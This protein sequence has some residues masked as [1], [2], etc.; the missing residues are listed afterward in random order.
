[1][2]KICIVG[3]GIA[4]L[5]AAY[6]LR[7]SFDCT[8]FEKESYAGGHTNTIDIE[9]SGKLLPID[10]G[11]I[12][13]NKYTYPNLVKLFKELNVEYVDSNM[14]FS[15]KNQKLN[16]EYNG[17]SIHTLFAQKKNIFSI[18]FL[19]F[20]YEINKFNK[21]SNQLFKQNK[22]ENISLKE[23]INKLSLSDFFYSNFLT[24]MSSA[25]WSMQANLM[26]NFPAHILIQFF[27]NHGFL[28]L[29]TQFQW[30]TVLGGSRQYVDK[31]TASFQ[32]NIKKD[33]SVLEVE[34]MS[35]KKVRVKT[36]QKTYFFEKVIFACHADQALSI[37]KNKT[38]LQ[39]ELL[40]PF[41]Y[42]KN[43]ATLHSD[44]SLMPKK[45]LAWASW[46]YII[47]DKKPPFTIYW[48]NNLQRIKSQKNYFV[49]INGED[50][51]DKKCIHKQIT[52]H[53]PIFNQETEAVQ[54]KMFLL[55]EEK[56]PLF[57]CGSYFKYGFHEDALQ[58]S[59]LLSEYLLNK[60]VL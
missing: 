6:F 25:V 58:S 21:I 3:T 7:S 19:K 44:E 30:K 60:K 56:N 24:P 1:M 35:S 15:V 37:I 2:E 39:Q 51:I 55:N 10:T 34:V 41:K 46:N 31:L 11:F 5:S 29:H 40:S 53:H 22:L 27:Y 54:K 59:V 8:I 48:M 13:F 4:G 20:L 57:F 42:Q 38:S 43:I 12:V 16:L 36:S 23:Y 33:E 49:N 32:Q 47:R 18:K 50:A 28:G 9:D 26:D 14:S 17:T 52:Y 45:K